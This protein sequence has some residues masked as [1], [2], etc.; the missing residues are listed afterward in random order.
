MLRALNRDVERVFNPD[1][2]ESALGTAQA[3]A[4]FL[5]LDAG[6]G[7]EDHCVGS[8]SPR[9]S[10]HRDEFLCWHPGRNTGVFAF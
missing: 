4:G 5:T 7:L 10:T 6:S 2:K 1:R 3:E 8:A 9:G